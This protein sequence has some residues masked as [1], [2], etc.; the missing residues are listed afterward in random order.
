MPP[1]KATKTDVAKMALK[2]QLTGKPPKLFKDVNAL[3]YSHTKHDRL[4]DARWEAETES[5]RLRFATAEEGS[6]QT[7]AMENA[8][9]RAV[10]LRAAVHD[11]LNKMLRLELDIQGKVSRI[12][13]ALSNAYYNQPVLTYNSGYV[14]EDMIDYDL[15]GEWKDG[16]V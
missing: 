3:Q 7:G 8:Y 15:R 12:P 10:A 9:G 2:R 16:Y 1:K 11:E 13:E 4:F 6:D 14:W 5:D